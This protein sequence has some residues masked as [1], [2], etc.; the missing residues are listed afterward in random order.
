MVF[1]V[2]KLTKIGRIYRNSGNIRTKEK[3]DSLTHLSHP[4]KGGPNESDPRKN[5]LSTTTVS[6]DASGQ[7]VNQPKRKC[8]YC[9]Y[10]EDPFFLKI[11]VRN[12]HSGA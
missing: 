6:R 1:D 5:D 4:S 3:T 9:N 7:S 10:E 11:H 8:P 2:N 12:S